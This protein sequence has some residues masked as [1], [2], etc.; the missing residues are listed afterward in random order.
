MS[1]SI[2]VVAALVAFVIGYI[3]YG[4][5]IARIYRLD[6]NRET[7]AHAK[8]DGVDYVPTK[9]PVLM[10]H[11]FASIAGAAPIIGPIVA[12][13]FGWVP[14]L[15]WIIIGSIFLGGVHDFSALVAS[16][17]HGGKTMGEVIEEHVGK[18][19]KRLF[20]AF[21]WSLVTLVIAVFAHAVAN[22]FVK[23]PAT[24]TASFL[25]IIVAIL[26]GMSV[27]RLNAPLWLSSVI[28]VALLAGCITLGLRFPIVLSSD[29]VRAY[30]LWKIA[31]FAYVF[32]AAVAPVWVLLQPRDYLS[33]FLLY[34]ILIASV[35]GVFVA[36]PKLESPAFTAF[37]VE[38][39]G[40][41]FPILFVTV[42]CGAI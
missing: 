29:P 22:V 14:V 4:R 25:F 15:L 37:H 27:Y 38:G 20:L 34:A 30:N 3:L 5:H 9:V 36:N 10:G 28:G 1:A 42:A 39:T 8:R 21:A 7:P 40:I 31:L 6:P 18:T 26:F 12:A 24:A 35:A 17:R 11:H 13:V 16:V 33:S 41:L 23:E 2:L 32:C 19:G